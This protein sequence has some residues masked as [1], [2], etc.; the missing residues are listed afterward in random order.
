MTRFILDSN[1]MNA[2]VARREPL[3]SRAQKARDA[4]HRLVTCEPIVAELLLGM[5]FSSSRDANL[6]RL[7]ANLNGIKSWPFDR[8]AS[9]EYAKVGAILRRNGRK[10]QLV[11]LMLAAVALSVGDCTVVT[12]DSD[13]SYVPGLSVVDWTKTT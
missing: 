1:A 13:L 6:K 7:K 4:G 2:L 11:D 8:K 10:I 5:E 9:Q 12:T 3:T